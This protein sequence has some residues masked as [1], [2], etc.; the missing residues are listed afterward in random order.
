MNRF[1]IKDISLPIPAGFF[2]AIQ[3]VKSWQGWPGPPGYESWSVLRASISAFPTLRKGRGGP[4]AGELYL[5]IENHLGKKGINCDIVAGTEAT[6]YNFTPMQVI[7]YLTLTNDSHYYE[8][9]AC[10]FRQYVLSLS[11]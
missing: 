9:N 8:F 2:Y 7:Q 1:N 3:R 6:I 11:G 10:D 4:F 5:R